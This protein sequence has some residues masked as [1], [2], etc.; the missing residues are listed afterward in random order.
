MGQKS[1]DEIPAGR[2][3]ARSMNG[4]P[5]LKQ[6]D[7]LGAAATRMYFWHPART[8]DAAQGGWGSESP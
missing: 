3:L 1:F 8:V 2:N 6:M 4:I 5:Q 7:L